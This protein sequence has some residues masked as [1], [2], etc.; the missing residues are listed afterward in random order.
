MCKNK[1]LDYANALFPTMWMQFQLHF[2]IPMALLF[3]LTCSHMREGNVAIFIR[4]EE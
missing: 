1:Q 3:P 4:A 2:S